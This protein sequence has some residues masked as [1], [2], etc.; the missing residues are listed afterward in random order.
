MIGNL[1]QGENPQNSGGIGVGCSML[2]SAENLQ[3]L[4]NGADAISICAKINDLG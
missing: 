4:R 2:F 1:V 3:Y